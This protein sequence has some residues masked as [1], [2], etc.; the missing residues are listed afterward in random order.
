MTNPHE[1]TN[2]NGHELSTST[3]SAS[4]SASAAARPAGLMT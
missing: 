3:T 4:A 2:D 1:A